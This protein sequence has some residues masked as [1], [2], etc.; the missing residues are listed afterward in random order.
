MHIKELY[1]LFI[2]ST[3][4]TTDSRHVQLNSIFFALKGKK[5]DGNKYAEN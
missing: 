4:V 2:K 1:S 3:G 5:F